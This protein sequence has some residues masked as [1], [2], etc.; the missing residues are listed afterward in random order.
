[1][2]KENYVG[3]LNNKLI[4]I[5]QQL[6]AGETAQSEILPDILMQIEDI[7]AEAGHTGVFLPYRQLRETLGLTPYEQVLICLLWYYKKEYGI[8]MEYFKMNSILKYYEKPFRRGVLAPCFQTDESRVY[9]SAVTFSF[10]Q[11]ELPEQ[12]QG[13]QL[14]VPVTAKMYQK[15]RLLLAGREL[16]REERAGGNS[17]PV[18]L[19][20]S[21]MPGS[22][23]EFV[24]EQLAAEN[25]LSLLSL[26]EAEHAYP[27]R[28]INEFVLC[29]GLYG[30]LVC[31]HV[32]AKYNRELLKELSHYLP[33][34]ILIKDEEVAVTAD[35]GY[36][37]VTQTFPRPDREIKRAVLEELLGAE[38]GPLDLNRAAI[39]AKQLPMGEFI[40]YVKGIREELRIGV[41]DE[42]ST[43]YRPGGLYLNLLPA[44]RS[45]EELKLPQDQYEK[46]AEICR[47]VEAKEKVM[48]QWGFEQ[49]FSYGNGISVLFYGAPGTGKTM[50]AQVMANR[51]SLPLFRVDLSQVVSK[52]IGD[53]QKNIGRIFAEA[54]RSNCILLFDEA[55]AV[56]AKRSEV[57]DAQDK[58]SNGET[59]YLL[60]QIEQYS[61]VSI[62]AT[63]LLQNFDEAFRRRITYMVHFPMPDAQL[64]AE[65]WE[66]IPPQAAE[67]SD[68]MDYQ[69]L[70]RLFELSGA[71]I[72][73][74]VMHGACCAMAEGGPIEMRHL[75]S[76]IRNEYVK[77]G[78]NLNE[79]QMELVN[80]VSN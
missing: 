33:F 52:Y 1:M 77:Q 44:N 17:D 80:A 50:A 2:S 67:L 64:R 56:F 58:Y 73:N 49:K 45:F 61:G 42:N 69:A 71:A 18:A 8:G 35:I 14:T 43:I 36:I 29:A 72:K 48:K 55:D 32:T 9:L 15:G 19:V 75:L 54:G 5:G 76:G 38:A 3:I 4:D 26:T 34:L 25:G 10:L 13:V 66:T 37:P 78:K 28:F 70:A 59:A 27:I 74:A 7:I 23:R 60:Q 46:L 24:A 41:F 40:R 65:L 31:V 63:N 12:Q 79:A 68:D 6:A 16:L 30:S 47:I 22:G 11:G 53:T 51:L 62:M 57:T 39:A 20:L 21:G